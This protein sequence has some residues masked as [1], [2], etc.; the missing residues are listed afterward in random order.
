LTPEEHKHYFADWRKK[1]G[2]YD[3]F[4]Q[5]T[6]EDGVEIRLPGTR[7]PFRLMVDEEARR[8]VIARVGRYGPSRGHRNPIKA[9][10]E[11]EGE[12]ETR[13]QVAFS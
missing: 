11:L 3:R 5:V 2:P 9:S 6:V 4:M 7:E 12:T 8:E 13:E 1:M 10:D